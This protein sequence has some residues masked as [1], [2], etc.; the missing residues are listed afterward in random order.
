MT[1]FEIGCDELQA[2]VPT[3]G[4]GRPFDLEK[5]TMQLPEQSLALL[6]GLCTSAPAGPLTSYLATIDRKLPPNFIGNTVHE[7]AF[8]VSRLWGK[9]GTEKFEQ[10]HPLYACNEHNF[11][12]HLTLVPK[13]EARPPELENSPRIHLIDSGMN[14][15]CSTY[16]MLHPKREVDIILNMDPSS[17]V[18]KDGFQQ[19]VDQIGARRGIKLTRRRD[20]KAGED[21]KDPDRFRGLYAQ[22]YDGKLQER[23]ETVVDS[24]GNTSTNPPAPIVHHESTMVYM[25][26]LP[27]E[28][29]VPGYDPSTA[30]FSG[31]YNL[32]W[33]PEQVEML[34]NMCKQNFADGQEEIKTVLR[35]TWIPKKVSREGNQ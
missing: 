10:H 17:D 31:P 2:W 28:R 26:S 3:W 24:Y 34:V 22:I 18:V 32:I 15:N 9:E 23:P 1:P 35:E 19:R 25:P 12:F 6:L 21:E 8:K 13:G 20:I 30:K 14:N 33:I 27:N 16:V 11:I 4:F 29:A 7:L 5:S